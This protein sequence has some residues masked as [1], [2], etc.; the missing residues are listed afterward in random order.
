MS[1]YNI[2]INV[3]EERRGLLRNIIKDRHTLSST[4]QSGL[5][6]PEIAKKINEMIKKIKVV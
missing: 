4:I 2:N 1:E 3:S 5:N 6:A